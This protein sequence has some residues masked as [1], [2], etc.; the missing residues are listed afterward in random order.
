MKQNN[1]NSHQGNPSA[2]TRGC[3]FIINI[4]YLKIPHYGAK[5]TIKKTG[6]VAHPPAELIFS[7]SKG[8]KGEKY[9][10]LAYPTTKPGSMAN[11]PIQQLSIREYITI[12][13]ECQEPRKK[14]INTE[15]ATQLLLEL[16]LASTATHQEIAVHIKT[17]KNENNRKTQDT[18]F[19]R[20]GCCLPEGDELSTYPQHRA[21]YSYNYSRQQSTK[22]TKDEQ[23]H[24]G[25]KE[26][27]LYRFDKYYS[28]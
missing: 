21:A 4:P 13:L 20:Y 24:R 17:V 8:N 12:W 9:R 15:R 6:T 14:T 26:E 23:L 2:I 1:I 19:R 27:T 10:R 28:F 22:R 5:T 3:P 7:D 16:S 25:P 11:R 18:C